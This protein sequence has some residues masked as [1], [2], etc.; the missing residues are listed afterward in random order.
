MPH[1]YNNT[2]HI[3]VCLRARHVVYQETLKPKSNKF[4]NSFDVQCFFVACVF[5]SSSP[6]VC[7]RAVYMLDLRVFMSAHIFKVYHINSAGSERRNDEK[8]GRRRQEKKPEKDELKSDSVTTA[9]ITKT[10]ITYICC[11]F[12]CASLAHCS[13][14]VYFRFLSSRFAFPM[15]IC[16]NAL[17]SG[18]HASINTF[19]VYMALL[20]HT[21]RVYIRSFI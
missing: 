16:G 20:A 19:S 2:G 3:Y 15:S 12:F 6:C 18:S 7:T 8:K 5:F 11:F 9:S 17:F 4:K 10:K 21:Y 14:I 1:S 13:V